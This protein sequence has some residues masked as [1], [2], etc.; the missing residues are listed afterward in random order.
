MKF[1]DYYPDNCPCSKSQQV[2]MTVFRLVK[3]QAGQEPPDKFFKSHK[4]RKPEENNDCDSCGLSVYTDINDAIHKLRD[5]NRR[6]SGWKIAQGIIY[7]E[8]GK[9]KPTPSRLCKSHATWWVPIGISPNTGF[10]ILDV[11]YDN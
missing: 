3:G 5:F 6:Y 7:P 1:P 10:K 4:E 2:T 8:S 11:N 9:F